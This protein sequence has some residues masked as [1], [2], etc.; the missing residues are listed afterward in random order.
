[1]EL[2]K[3]LSEP[4][5]ITSNTME[6]DREAFVRF[7]KKIKDCVIDIVRD[8][9]KSFNHI[10][11]LTILLSD[12]EKYRIER[13]NLMDENNITLKQTTSSVFGLLLGMPVAL[14]LVSTL[15]LTSPLLIAATACLV[16]L[17][18]GLGYLAIRPPFP[19]SY[20]YDTFAKTINYKIYIKILIKLLREEGT[21]EKVIEICDIVS[22]Q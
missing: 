11:L 22:Q 7:E 15:S 3:D 17:G 19:E 14:L 21:M 4:V 6:L 18:G 2:D 16:P 20:L 12:I 10:S 5:Y 9:D 1:M 8:E 13:L